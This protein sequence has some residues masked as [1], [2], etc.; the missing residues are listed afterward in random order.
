MDRERC[1]VTAL[2]KGLDN[3]NPAHLH[4]DAPTLTIKSILERT[5]I[6]VHRSE[7]RNAAMHVLTQS[8]ALSSRQLELPLHRCLNPSTSR[9]LSP[10][11]API[12]HGHTSAFTLQGADR[13]HLNIGR[14]S[15]VS[16]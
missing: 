7:M 10:E 9:Q 15:L 4:L 11:P 16:E 13:V 12:R 2:M 6:R 14:P 3:V 5:G 1:S 8:V